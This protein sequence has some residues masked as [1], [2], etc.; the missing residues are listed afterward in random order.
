M[1]VLCA[2]CLLRNGKE[3]SLRRV[4]DLKVHVAESHKAEERLLSDGL[5]SDFFSEG[6]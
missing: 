1:R 6:K 3:K 2:F 5:P 4:N